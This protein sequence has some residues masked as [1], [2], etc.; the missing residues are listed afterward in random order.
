MICTASVIAELANTHQVLL[1]DLGGRLLQLGQERLF[2]GHCDLA[3]VVLDS[4]SNPTSFATELSLVRRKV[5][6]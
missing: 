2:D 6:P 4:I 3:V 5:Q 1:E